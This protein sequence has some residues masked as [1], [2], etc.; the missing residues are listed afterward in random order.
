MTIANESGPNQAEIDA[1]TAFMGMA[2]PANI[3]AL[4]AEI[5]NIG[6]ER[7]DLKAEVQRLRSGGQ[8]SRGELE[9]LEEFKRNVM[10]NRR[11]RY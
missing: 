3:L 8:V 5:E 10:E 7:N 9:R 2:T 1:V 4:L 11:D 6:S